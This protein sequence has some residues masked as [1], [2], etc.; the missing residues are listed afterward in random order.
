[1]MRGWLLVVVMVGCGER[2]STHDVPEGHARVG[3][4]VVSTVEG[5]PIEL[6]SVES[7]ALSAQL[8]PQQALERRQAEE[9]LALEAHRRG[10][11]DRDEPK[12]RERQRMVQAL[13]DRLA[14]RVTLDSISEEDVRARFARR[15][16]ELTRPERRAI[17]HIVVRVDSDAD[18]DRWSE[19]E[20]LARRIRGEWVTDPSTYSRYRDTETLESFALHVE[21]SGL[22]TRGNL[23]SALDEAVFGP[24]DTGI[25]AE[26]HRSSGG[27]H[28]VEVIRI[29]T[30]QAPELDDY[31]VQMREEI[32]NARRQAMLVELVDEAAERFEVQVDEVVAARALALELER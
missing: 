19:A 12:L 23:E 28:V 8:D 1:M 13:L 3:G 16:G 25:L 26:P 32:A 20:R 10:Y 31:V 27:W 21:G 30:A 22:M 9:L 2:A 5:H 11:A 24:S 29:E 7:L 6:E 17:R 15:R 14:E 4:D 18:D